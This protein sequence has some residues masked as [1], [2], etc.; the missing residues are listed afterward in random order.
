[1][2]QV[3]SLQCLVLAGATQQKGGFLGKNSGPSMEGAPRVRTA[4]L[5]LFSH[6][7]ERSVSIRIPEFGLIV[8]IREFI[9]RSSQAKLT[10]PVGYPLPE[11]VCLPS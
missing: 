10:R 1:M 4:A 11:T 7:L 6:L 8:A 9:T 2:W 5:G 3:W